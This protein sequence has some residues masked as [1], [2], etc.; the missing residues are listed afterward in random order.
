MERS[1]P[2]GRAKRST[3]ILRGGS[4]GRGEEGGR[5]RL[6]YGAAPPLL[7]CCGVGGGEEEEKR[8]EGD[9]EM[10]D[11]EKERGVKECA[12]ESLPERECGREERGRDA[13]KSCLAPRFGF[14]TDQKRLACGVR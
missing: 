11:G 14:E 4:A 2:G 12:A 8:E 7:C 3:M 10:H 5:G 6:V 1:E 13:V 9:E